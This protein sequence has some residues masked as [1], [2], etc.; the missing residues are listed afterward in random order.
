[1]ASRTHKD[2]EY[3]ISDVNE[4]RILTTTNAREAMVRALESAMT[5]GRSYLD[6]LIWSEAG[7]KFFGGT[8]ALEHYRDDPEAS[9]FERFEIKVNAQGRIP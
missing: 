4:H 6:V 7:A 9:I 5:S 1:M 8:D 3:E 2:V